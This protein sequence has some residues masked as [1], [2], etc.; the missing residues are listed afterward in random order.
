M[1][2]FYY[3]PLLAFILLIF[4]CRISFVDK[5]T[6]DG[7]EGFSMLLLAATRKSLCP[8]EQRNDAWGRLYYPLGFFW[9]ALNLARRLKRLVEQ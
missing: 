5:I 8:E 1:P 9:L 2:E 4:Y 3:I 7:V 6:P